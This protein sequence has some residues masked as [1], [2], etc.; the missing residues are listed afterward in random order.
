MLAQVQL[1]VGSVA[2]PFEHRSYGDELA[3]CQRYYNQITLIRAGSQE[4]VSAGY[5]G[6]SGR[7]WNYCYPEMR[8]APTATYLNNTA[9]NVQYYHYTG[10]YWQNSNAVAWVN[11]N[12]YHGF[13]VSVNTSGRPYLIRK[14]GSTDLIVQLSAEL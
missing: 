4:I 2:T 9:G 3:R 12:Q 1:E 13:Y 14:T 6:S 10:N 7:S 5:G 8:A 11:Q